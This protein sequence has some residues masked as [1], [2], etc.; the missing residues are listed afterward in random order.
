MGESR[1]N[2]GLVT[3]PS[4]S[5]VVEACAGSGKTW[6]LT[7]RI[8]RSLLSGVAP[9]EILALTYTKKAAA[10]MRVRVR[11]VLETLAI[12]PTEQA[13]EILSSYGLEGPGLAAALARVDSAYEE[14]LL[15][16]VPATMGTFHSWYTQILSY[17]PVA[18]APLST[19]RVT[20]QAS[21]LETTLW[22]DFLAT[23]SEQPAIELTELLRCIGPTA[24]REALTDVSASWES[25]LQ[26]VA[27]ESGPG[28]EESRQAMRAAR[29]AFLQS[30][31]PLANGLRPALELVSDKPD[32]ARLFGQWPHIEHDTLT[33]FLLVGNGSHGRPRMRLKQRG[34]LSKKDLAQ[35]GDAADQVWAAIQMLGNEWAD[36]LDRSELVLQSAVQRALCRAALVWIE[37]S[38]RWTRQ[39][40]ETT[41][42]GLEQAA[43][44]LVGSELGPA[45]L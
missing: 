14:W 31:A 2:V 25:V 34:L 33:G 21:V 42:D 17:S 3:D 37:Q 10:E 39:H 20:E 30:R 18:A 41:Y 15:A 9:S 36:C 29:D 28:I 44:G 11:D 6:L 35:M 43:L 7:A 8:V 32:W 13:K 19:L 45:L 1:V 26:R 5:V 12:C 22:R 38:N 27:A 24:L 4:R 23:A 40:N 16:E